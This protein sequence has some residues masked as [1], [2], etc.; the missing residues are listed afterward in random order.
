MS[1]TPSG[2]SPQPDST[3]I[4]WQKLSLIIFIAACV[5]A[6][7]IYLRQPQ[8]G[9]GLKGRPLPPLST[10]GWIGQTSL[11]SADLSGKVVVIDFWA[12]WCGPCRSE[13]K[14]LVET[15]QKYAGNSDVLFIGLTSQTQSEVPAMQDF[16]NSLNVPWPNAYGADEMFV[17]LNIEAIPTV[18]VV[19]REGKIVYSHTGTGSGDLSRVIDSAL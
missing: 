15:Y 1:T 13:T 8:D 3:S 16:I 19:D 2:P 10:S 9:S 6:A 14:H 5:Y 18:L 7:M 11:T 12:S 17:D 4:D